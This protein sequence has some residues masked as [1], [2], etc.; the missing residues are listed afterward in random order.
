M[1][2]SRAPRSPRC[3]SSAGWPTSWRVRWAGRVSDR[4]GRKPL[5][6][7]ACIGLGFAMIVTTYVVGDL[8]MGYL[9]FGGAMVMVAM[10]TSP[11][12][13]L[14]TAIVPDERRG[15]LMSPRHRYW[16]DRLWYR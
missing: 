9:L 16:A 12:Q 4:I 2:A 13:A 7:T 15:I 1:W 11:L 3:S 8:L 10:R 6:V 14:M 5:I